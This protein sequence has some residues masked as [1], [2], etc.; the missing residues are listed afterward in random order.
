MLSVIGCILLCIVITY[1]GVRINR[2]WLPILLVV[3]RTGKKKQGKTN[4]SLS[5]FASEKLVSRREM[6][7]AV[8]SCVVTIG[9]GEGM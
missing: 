6:G 3:S 5:P 7:L 1:S 2:I 4:K 9:G 8:P